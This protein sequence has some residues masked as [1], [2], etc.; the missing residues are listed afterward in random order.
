MTDPKSPLT[1]G[2]GATVFR[3]ASTRVGLLYAGMGLL[4]AVVLAVV[5]RDIGHHI[6]AIESW[7]A[8]LGPWGVLAF[9]VLF[10]LATTVLFPETVLA[11]MAGALFGLEVGL[12]AVVVGGFAAAA[13]QYVLARR[14]LRARIQRALSGKPSLAAI[15]RAVTRSEVRLQALLRLTPLNPATLNFA[16]G[17]AG[18][19]FSGFLLACFALVPNQLIEVYF[20]YAGRHVAKMAGRSARAVYLHDVTV[21]GGLIICTVVMVV[22]S[23]MARRAVAQTVAEA[24]AEA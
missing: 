19:R 17:A 20:G 11:I 8:S 13:L 16:F 7:I 23:R 21:V 3:A 1:S 18:V 4:L 14:V 9:I 5:G 24:D 10:V 6:R 2:D 22:V 12:V 15:Q